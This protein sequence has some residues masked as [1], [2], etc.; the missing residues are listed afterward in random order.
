[1]SRR[2]VLPSFLLDVISCSG[3]NLSNT[4]DLLF[5]VLSIAV[6]WI[7]VFLCWALYELAKLLHQSNQVVTETRSKMSRV[8]SAVMDVKERLESS[9]SYVGMLAEGGKAVMSM[10]T[11]KVKARRASWR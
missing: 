10:S 7:A 4:Q 2:E 3:M 8:E 1:M 9:L 11:S 6:A 5:L